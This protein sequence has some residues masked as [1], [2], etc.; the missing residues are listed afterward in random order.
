MAKNKQDVLVERIDNLKEYMKEEFDKIDVHLIKL[1]GQ[2]A[3]N[4]TFR[5]K[6]KGGLILSSVIIG[7]SGLVIIV[8]A[9]ITN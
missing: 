7:S 5:N 2:V 6:L 4:T 3:R 1:N 9:L 8:T